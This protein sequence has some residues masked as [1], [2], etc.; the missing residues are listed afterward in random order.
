MDPKRIKSRRD[1]N[2]LILVLEE[3]KVQ[4]EYKISHHWEEVKET[5]SPRNLIRKG[6][7]NL[8]VE[9]KSNPKLIISGIGL[10]LGFLVRKLI[11]GKSP[12]MARKL[13]GTAVQVGISSLLARKSSADGAVN[14]FKK[15]FT[16]KKK[17]AMLPA[18]PSSL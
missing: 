9:G 18:N 11:L 7:G 4:Q 14:V 5:Y 1:L 6:F 2:D 10:G 8:I 15:I 12:G 13:A 16:K 17:P 3:A